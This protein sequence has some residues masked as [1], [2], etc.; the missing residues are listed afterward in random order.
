MSKLNKPKHAKNEHINK[1]AGGHKG[2]GK[3]DKKQESKKD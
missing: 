1:Y 2:K 3:G